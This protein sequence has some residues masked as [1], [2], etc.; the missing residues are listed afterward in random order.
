M[1]GIDRQLETLRSE[2]Q[3][4]HHAAAWEAVVKLC[5]KYPQHAG[6]H[7]RQGEFAWGLDRLLEAKAAF[8]A[9]LKLN[10]KQTNALMGLAAVRRRLGDLYGAKQSLLAADALNLRHELLLREWLALAEET[11]LN[12]PA[13][14]ALKRQ[15]HDGLDD[16]LTTACLYALRKLGEYEAALKLIQAVHARRAL[17]KAAQV[18]AVLLDIGLKSWTSAQQKIDALLKEDL[19]PKERSAVAYA[20]GVLKQSQQD[21][22]DAGACFQEALHL[23]PENQAAARARAG[24]WL[25]VGEISKAIEA[26][27]ALAQNGASAD[28]EALFGMTQAL[29]LG[30]R[31]V[32]WFAAMAALENSSLGA[33]HPFR[34]WNRCNQAI[35]F[36]LANR[37][38][39][40]YDTLESAKPILQREEEN[41]RFYRIYAKYLYRL[42]MW[43]AE[44]QATF[45]QGEQDGLL[46][47]I[48]ESHALT[49]NYSLTPWSAGTLRCVTH[50]VPGA[51]AFHI[52]QLTPNR[53]RAAL[54]SILQ[55]IQ[56]GSHLLFCVGEIDCRP[57][58]GIWKVAKDNTLDANELAKQTASAYIQGLKS[59]LAEK[60]PGSVTIQGVPAPGYPFIDVYD[61]G[62]QEAFVEMIQC[63]NVALKEAAWANGWGFLDVYSATKNEVGVGNKT[64]HID[65]FH[66]QPGFYHQAKQWLVFPEHATEVSSTE[67]FQ[68]RQS[69]QALWAAGDMARLIDAAIVFCR[70]TPKDAF[71]WKILGCARY[72]TQ[73][74]AAAQAALQRAM[75]LNR[76]DRET[77]EVL[78]LVERQLGHTAEADRLQH[79]AHELAAPAL[80]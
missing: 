70:S 40:A 69:L 3:A 67:M 54:T 72:R 2:W 27:S 20:Q 62:N 75:Q 30:R 44:N 29:L 24:N 42:L 25:E 73:E 32:D 31:F 11:G 7:A 46:H 38:N 41:S 26:Y 19:S 22:A 60:I 4:G 61:P 78:S 50:W 43:R 9:A 51:K 36:Y 80:S 76:V 45:G 21:F 48:G 13:R 79:I 68:A 64:W 5:A 18:E 74:W 55:Q 12:A 8:E 66:L 49:V 28:P 16:T 33:E 71:G 53:Y 14:L 58:E 17:G 47:V 77:V 23:D 56:H 1:G 37:L 52:G 65:P 6:V 39:E 34:L 63:F 10:P 59:L 57:N 15:L 35:G